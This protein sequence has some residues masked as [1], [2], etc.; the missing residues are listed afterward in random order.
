[1]VYTD[2]AMTRFARTCLVSLALAGAG[3]AHARDARAQAPITWSPLYPPGYERPSAESIAPR[4][5]PAAYRP[6]RV[7]LWTAPAPMLFGLFA[8][9]YS[10]TIG[11]NISL[12]RGLDLV[13]RGG[14]GIYQPRNAP[15]PYFAVGGGSVGLSIFLTGTERMNG[16]FVTPRVGLSYGYDGSSQLT[17][18][19]VLWGLEAGYQIA[20]DGVFVALLLGVSNGFRFNDLSIPTNAGRQS[21]EYQSV[22][23]IE[24][25]RLGFTL[26]DAGRRNDR[27]AALP[28]LRTADQGWD[29]V[30]DRAGRAG[31]LWLNP[32][33]MLMGPVVGAYYSVS[34]GAM[35][36]MNRWMAAVVEGSY[37]RSRFPGP[38][39]SAG[40]PA[41]GNH[42]DFDLGLGVAFF[43]SSRRP[44]NGGFVQ[45]I[46]H[47]RYTTGSPQG[48][49]NDAFA[50]G[51][52]ADVGYS[53]TV[54][55]VYIAPVIGF[56]Y[57]FVEP[58][59]RGGAAV[60]TIAQER[61]VVPQLHLAIVRLGWAF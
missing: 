14:L 11:A 54:G 53:I 29:P 22:F 13:V 49:V 36:A 17:A 58:M 18:P 32:L 27:Q 6:A 8:Q 12:A 39:G 34:G 3:F 55:P 25:L 44:L 16:V 19:I 4:G 38:P 50:F 2:A 41:V 23:D 60:S 51:I 45:P 46:I 5:N 35:L 7:A 42:A 20:R 9:L 57:D 26:G 40:P 31:A 28:G 33:S 10:V 30:R 24:I 59:A 52:G 56:G 21:L 1:M 37:S 15:A 43:F 48:S 47:G 61:G